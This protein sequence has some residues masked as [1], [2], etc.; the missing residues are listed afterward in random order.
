MRTLSIL[1]LTVGLFQSTAF[2]QVTLEECLTKAR[3]NYPMI[4]QYELIEKSK[5]YTLSNANKSY[6]PQL[7]VTV[8]G[9]VISGLPSFSPPGTESSSSVDFN[10]ISVIQLN[11]VIWDGGITKAIKQM[12]E[13]GS[14]IEKA[15]LEVAL[16][17]IRERVNNL[18]FGI[19]LIEEQ[20]KQLDYLKT[21]M[22]RNI[23]RVEVAIESGTAFK[24]DL[25]EIKVE[26]INIDQ[27]KEEL[28]SNRSA[29]ISVLSAMIG[30]LISEESD[31]IKPEMTDDLLT[32]VNNRPELRLFQ[33]REYLIE[34]QQ[35]VNKSQLY[36]KIGLLG[37]GTYI[38]P[39]VAFGTSDLTNVFVGGLSLNWSIGGLYKN[40]N[41]KK[42]AEID[43]Q[44]VAVQ[45]ET[46]LFNNKLETTQ[47][48][49]EL[50]KYT[51]LIDQDR[52]IIELKT[53]IKKAYEV[54]YENGV[55]TLAE[56]LDR[57]NDES[58]A[59]QNLIVHEIQYLMK[60]NEYLIETGN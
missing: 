50:T 39:G 31:F 4:K 35:A 25:D 19:L 18:F 16:Y 34:A 58:V 53:R 23:D 52:E 17:S 27:K 47:T 54:K 37:L 36:P 8:I 28:L 24:S 10:M 55:S 9:G 12:T 60:A 43:L 32:L 30:E 46:F 11:Q 29:Y 5:G 41:N 20:T 38:A 6:L 3:E 51:T 56:L 22:T 26:L 1:L 33:N 2:G 45:R 40:G 57:T 48:Q 21:V 59:R 44:K 15:D 7:D 49:R 13:A 14:E 42:L